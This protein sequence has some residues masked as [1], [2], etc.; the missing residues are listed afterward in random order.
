LIRELNCQADAWRQAEL[1]KARKQI[2]KGDALDG[3]LESL[4][5]G[6]MKKMLNGP[7]RELHHAQAAQLEKTREAIRHMFLKAEQNSPKV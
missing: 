1:N 6:L 7:L 4:S 2:E 5:M 3:V